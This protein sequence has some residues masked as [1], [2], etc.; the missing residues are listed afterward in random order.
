[1]RVLEC[2]VHGCRDSCVRACLL[3][4]FG[5]YCR[6]QHGPFRFTDRQFLAQHIFSTFSPYSCFVTPG[7]V[8]RVLG[9]TG[10]GLHREALHEEQ[11]PSSIFLP[12][13]RLF[14]LLSP[15]R[16][17]SLPIPLSPF[18]LVWAFPSPSSHSF[19][20]LPSL[21]CPLVPPSTLPSF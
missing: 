3:L 11:L 12:L 9:M 4:F 13:V 16:L 21:S 10:I 2:T 7:M 6:V 5:S 1:M 19:S 8:E 18:F 17:S 15:S 14:P 20:S